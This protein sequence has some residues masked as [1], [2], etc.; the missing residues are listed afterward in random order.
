MGIIGLDLKKQNTVL[1]GK[2]YN[3]NK[4]MNEMNAIVN[5]C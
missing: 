4:T 3:L 5:H 2:A 1:K